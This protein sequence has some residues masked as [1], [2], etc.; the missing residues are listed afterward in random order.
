MSTVSLDI[1][2]AVGCYTFCQ[3]HHH[4]PSQTASSSFA[5][6]QIILFGD[7][8]VRFT[9]NALKLLVGQQE[10]HLACKT[11]GVGLLVVMI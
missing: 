11:L 5:Q 2:L 4:L 6:Y 3:A 8:N 9:F 10:E 7:R 1:K